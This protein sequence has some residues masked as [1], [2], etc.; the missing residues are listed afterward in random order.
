MSVL[1]LPEGEFFMAEWSPEWAHLFEEERARIAAALGDMILDIQHVGSTSVAWLCAKPVLDIAIGVESFEK[2]FETVTPLEAIDYTFR[3]EFGLP[4]RHYFIKGSPRTHQVHMWEIASD[5]WKRHIAFR[6]YLRA[7]D[8]ARDR[9][10]A[11]KREM[12]RTAKTRQ[13][14]QDLKDPL[15]QELQREALLQLNMK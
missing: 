12:S 10:A 5:D 6:D 13:E 1:G 14:Y 8:D 2:A 7:N 4:R 3:G 9:Y 15:I 11:M